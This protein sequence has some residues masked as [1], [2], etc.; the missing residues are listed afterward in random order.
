MSGWDDYYGQAAVDDRRRDRY[1]RERDDD[2]HMSS[3]YDRD[4]ERERYEAW[5]KYERERAEWE[6]RRDE[7]EQ[8]AAGGYD[9]GYGT[10]LHTLPVQYLWMAN[11][12]PLGTQNAP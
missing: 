3:V 10:S 9:Y 12:D 4:E 1:S 6:R 8:S 11:A 5:E 2:V 7:L